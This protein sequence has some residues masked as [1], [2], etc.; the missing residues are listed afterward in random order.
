MSSNNREPIISVTIKKQD[1]YIV[2]DLDLQSLPI[3]LNQSK[4]FNEIQNI[5]ILDQWGF[6]YCIR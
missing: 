5:S 2:V 3:D 6:L 1:Y 4:Y